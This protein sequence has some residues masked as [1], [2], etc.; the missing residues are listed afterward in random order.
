MYLPQVTGF[1]LL[2]L[3]CTIVRPGLSAHIAVETI[4]ALETRSTGM[5]SAMLSYFEFT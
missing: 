2:E 1:T 3:E 4:I 5:I